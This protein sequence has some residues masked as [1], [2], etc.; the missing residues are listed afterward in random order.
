MD[1]PRLEILKQLRLSLASEGPRFA[2]FLSDLATDK[3]ISVSRE[4]AQGLYRL[5]DCVRSGA[6]LKG[7]ERG[8]LEAGLRALGYVRSVRQAERTRVSRF[9]PLFIQIRLFDVGPWQPRLRPFAEWF[10]GRAGFVIC[11]ALVIAAITMGMRNDW[12]I[13][14]EFSG[15]FNLDTLLAFGLIAPFLK[16]IH[17]FGHVTVATAYGVRVRN[18]ALSLI[19]L[20]PLP[21]VDCSE[22]D[23]TANRYQRVMISLAGL[24]TDLLVGTIAFLCWHFVEND[25]IR[26]LAGRVVVFSTLNSLLFNANPLMKFDG[27]YAMADMIGQRSLYT[28][29]VAGFN[30]L[31]RYVL[32]LGAGGKRP[33]GREAW[34]VTGYGFLTFC[35]RITITISILT[36]VLPQYL[37][38]G[39]LMGAWGSYVMFVSPMVADPAPKAADPTPARRLWLGRAGFAA[40]LAL[41]VFFIPLPFA[42]HLE[43]RLDDGGHYAVTTEAS[44]F[45]TPARQPSGQVAAQA[46][47]LAV[48]N[49]D[50]DRKRD[51]L[52]RELSEARL[53]VQ[54]TQSLGAAEAQ[55]AGEKERSILTQMAV[56]QSE[57]GL[58]QTV[59][60]TAGLFVPR[61]DLRPGKFLTAGETIGLLYPDTGDATLVGQYPERWV[62]EFQKAGPSAELR[63][64]GRYV[65][66]PSGAIRLVEGTTTDAKTG[67]RS[68]ALYAEL[69][70]IPADLVGK[71]IE[72]RLNFGNRPIIE[73]LK[74]WANGKL[75]AFRDAQIADRETRLGAG[76]LR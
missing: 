58:Q 48:A 25:A 38:A 75:A 6:P 11:L 2:Y 72:I 22:A 31:T 60:A 61:A 57:A 20:Y 69:A 28:R 64:S 71:D 62:E 65:D 29:G 51:L 45:V 56:A 36:R 59:A 74:F 21:S 14:E 39:L 12:A 15:A 66:L 37:G 33:R 4:V 54:N 53:L 44:G 52:E 41:S 24:F 10:V 47:L 27:Y 40:C 67:L 19:A 49:P 76:T 46:R 70:Q 50:L 55:L 43:M 1:H 8:Q 26:S 42:L 34:G 5:T 30:G 7:M 3:I 17:E 16:I 73:H 9:N 63:I 13:R 23:V 18:A 68:I 35:Y 32:S